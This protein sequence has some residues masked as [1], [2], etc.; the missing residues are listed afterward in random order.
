ML[1]ELTPCR[2]VG[3]KG[4]ELR[5]LDGNLSES[6]KFFNAEA[7]R[8]RVVLDRIYRI[9]RIFGVWGLAAV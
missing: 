2:R 3:D 1:V 6:G 5:V 8:R 9:D 7:Q 4:A